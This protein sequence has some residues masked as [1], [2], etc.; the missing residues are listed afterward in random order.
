MDPMINGN[1]AQVFYPNVADCCPLYGQLGVSKVVLLDVN[2]FYK[3]LNFF[4]NLC[5]RISF[6]GV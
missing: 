6:A 2:F 5:F 1:N 4:L 3:E